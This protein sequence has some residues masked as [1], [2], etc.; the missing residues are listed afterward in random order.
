[1]LTQETGLVLLRFGG[2]IDSGGV[3]GST[4][5][6]TPTTLSALVSLDSRVRNQTTS[7]GS[8]N[9]RNFRMLPHSLLL[10][11]L[12]PSLDNDPSAGSHTDT[13]LRLL[14]P[15]NDIF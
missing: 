9:Q 1:M 2:R 7:T 14:L 15:L 3:I 12:L 11:R 10:S 6:T 4:C 13:L 8:I 5:H